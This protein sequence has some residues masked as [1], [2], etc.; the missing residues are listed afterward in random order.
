MVS[1]VAPHVLSKSN[2]SHNVK[3]KGKKGAHKQ[4]VDALYSPDPPIVLLLGE[5]AGNSIPNP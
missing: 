3:R 2:M 5:D 4:V 1:R